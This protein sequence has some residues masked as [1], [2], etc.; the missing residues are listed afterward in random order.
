M[1]E[2]GQGIRRKGGLIRTELQLIDEAYVLQAS[3]LAGLELSDEQLPGVLEH[4][5]RTAQAAALV[6]E[7]F[8][9][10]EDEPGPTWQ[11]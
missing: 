1:G 6:N 5:R 4:L 11:P 2:G 3:R 9:G 8:L 10:M 7:F